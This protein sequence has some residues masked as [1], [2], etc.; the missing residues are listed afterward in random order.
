MLPCL[1]I[2]MRTY[3]IQTICAAAAIV[4]Y[5]ECPKTGRLIVRPTGSTLPARLIIDVN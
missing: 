5:V 3:S 2:V 1:S 4:T